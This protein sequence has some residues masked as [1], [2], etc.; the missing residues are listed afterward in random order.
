MLDDTELQ[1]TDSATYLGI[2]FDKRQTRK[3]HISKADAKAR[4]KLA[5][6]RKLVGTNGVLQTVVLRIVYIGTIRP[7]LEYGS[8]TL[9]SAFKSTH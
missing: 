7:H 5:L 6:L 3:T 2:T 4:R 1:R 8:T 9:S